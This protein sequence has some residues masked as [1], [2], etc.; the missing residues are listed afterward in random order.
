MSYSRRRLLG[1][2]LGLAGVFALG[3]GDSCSC[4]GPQPE[5]EPVTI[6]IVRHAEKRTPEDT[7]GMDEATKKDPPLSR[8][9][10]LR[11]MSLT[12]DIPAETLDA[13]YVTKT[14][15]SEHT[16]APVVALTGIEPIH[17]PPRDVEGLV[18][19]L[20]KRS[21]QSVL[22]V[23]HSNTIP[24]LLGALGLDKPTIPED[25]YGDLWVVRLRES[26]ASV[27]LRDFGGSAEPFDPGL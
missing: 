7:P 15:R 16:A 27:E 17:Y 2:G 23:G 10:E 21:G 1:L 9:G 3:C 24:E 19:R 22:I 5:P 8:A 11:A 25:Q 13:I 18:E 4:E 26:G 20:R 14:K 6:Y 12:E